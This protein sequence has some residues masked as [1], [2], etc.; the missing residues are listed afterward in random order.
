MARQVQRQQA[1]TAPARTPPRPNAVVSFRAG[2]M[3]VD[4]ISQTLVRTIDRM[5]S[6]N[7]TRYTAIEWADP[8]TDERRTSCNCPGWANRRACKH[9]KELTD[10][11]GIGLLTDDVEL[12]PQITARRQSVTRTVAGRPLRGFTFLD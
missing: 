5:S 12:P 1:A 11:S 4:G 8:A 2:V 7:V 10:D 6:N 3:L 9:V